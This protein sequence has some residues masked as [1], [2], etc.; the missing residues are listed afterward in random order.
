MRSAVSARGI[1]APD[2]ASDADDR[3]ADDAHERAPTLQHATPTLQHA[4]PTDDAAAG[5]VQ[6]GRAAARAA[7]TACVAAWLAASYEPCGCVAPTCAH[8]E[9]VW[10]ARFKPD[11][12]TEFLRG[13]PWAASYAERVD[14][15]AVVVDAARRQGYRPLLA[16]ATHAKLRVAFP[17]GTRRRVTGV[18]GRMRRR[19]VAAAL[20]TA[21]VRRRTNLAPA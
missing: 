7:V 12:V 16:N 15:R 5:P 13:H 14:L 6:A 17:D 8:L 4:T 11:L 9:F 21:P 10:R 3:V 18:V 2:E 20:L 19:R 1:D